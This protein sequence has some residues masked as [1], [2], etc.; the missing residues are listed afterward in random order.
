MDEAVLKE[1]RAINASIRAGVYFLSVA[2]V[3]VHYLPK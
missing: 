2:M 3:I 1:L